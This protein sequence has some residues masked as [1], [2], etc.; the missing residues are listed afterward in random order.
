MA[1]IWR[2]KMWLNTIQISILLNFPNNELFRTWIQDFQFID[3]KFA[4][5]CYAACIYRKEHG[6]KT[7]QYFEYK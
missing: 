1:H 6:Y 5:I 7:V 2:V 3:Q 4:T